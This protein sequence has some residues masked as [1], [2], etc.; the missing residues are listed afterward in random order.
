M[1]FCGLVIIGLVVAGVAIPVALT[2]NEDGDEK[3]TLPT[4]PP[5]TRP[6]PL[7]TQQVSDFKVFRGVVAIVL[8]S[9]RPTIIPERL[10]R[11]GATVKT[12][13]PVNTSDAMVV[14]GAQ[15]RPTD[16]WLIRQRFNM[17][18]GVYAC[19]VAHLRG[20]AMGCKLSPKTPF[21]MLE[22]DATLDYVPYWPH[23]DVMKMLQRERRPWTSAQLGVSNLLQGYP[24]KK[25][26][27]IR[28]VRNHWGGYATA[29]HPRIEK[30]L[31][32]VDWC[33]PAD[34]SIFILGRSVTSIP[35]LFGH[36]YS[37]QGTIKGTRADGVHLN[38]TRQEERVQQTWARMH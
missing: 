7:P 20:L 5:T 12:I 36:N 27:F 32:Y 26:M 13:R 3:T 24:R 6:L 25:H 2:A 37:Q 4:P 28:W 1:L 14:R 18:V 34:M 19:L 22:D 38:G 10:R 33:A 23:A 30:A 8:L 21:L 15:C 11:E 31:P 9:G 29:H 16:P 17:S 35:P